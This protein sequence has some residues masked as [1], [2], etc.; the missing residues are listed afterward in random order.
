MK[1]P[2]QIIF[3]ISSLC[4]L[5][6]TA[7]AG[8]HEPSVNQTSSVVGALTPAEKIRIAQAAGPSNISDDALILDTD[9]TV[10]QEGG[11]GW[12]CMVGTPPSYGNPMCM[13]DIWVNFFE[14]YYQK[15]PFEPSQKAIG[16]SYMLVGDLPMDNDD[17]FNLDESKNTWVQEGPHLMLLVP[18]SLFGALPTNPYVGGP[19]V[20]WQDSQYAHIMVPL[21]KTEPIFYAD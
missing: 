5:A 18:Q 12:T 15:A 16:F 4:S 17:P 3:F 21:E 9:K 14:A 8:H 19:Y 1:T 10:L 13:D 11:N 7:H 2:M 6:L 20:M